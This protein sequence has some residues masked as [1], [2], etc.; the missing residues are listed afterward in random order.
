MLNRTYSLNQY[1]AKGMRSSKMQL[2]SACYT[3]VLHLRISKLYI[4]KNLAVYLSDARVTFFC[5]LHELRNTTTWTI[6]ARFESLLNSSHSSRKQILREI[7][8]CVYTLAVA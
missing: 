7:V 6:R 2:V 3:A 4:F 5:K 8:C 1:H